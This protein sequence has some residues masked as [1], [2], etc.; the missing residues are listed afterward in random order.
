[1]S[2]ENTEHGVNLWKNTALKLLYICMA[3]PKNF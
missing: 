2:I 1:M 3:Y